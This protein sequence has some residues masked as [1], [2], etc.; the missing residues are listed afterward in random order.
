[1]K[2][3][4][5]R[6]SGDDQ[7]D[8]KAKHQINISTKDNSGK[9]SFSLKIDPSW[10]GSV[11]HSR[12]VRLLE[13][14]MLPS[15]ARFLDTSGRQES[16]SE[17]LDVYIKPI[18]KE[19]LGWELRVMRRASPW[20]IEIRLHETPMEIEWDTRDGTLDWRSKALLNE[21]SIDGVDIARQVNIFKRR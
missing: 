4:A 7:L 12:I 10:F 2:V 14:V 5:S 13:E 17:I 6:I 18:R 3:L 19:P 20:E 16:G 11:E 15:L 9:P 1:V 21:F 8:S